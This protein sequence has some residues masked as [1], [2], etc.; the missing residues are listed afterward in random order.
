MP[1]CQNRDPDS[2]DESDEYSQECG[3]SNS[4]EDEWVYI[5]LLNNFKKEKGISAGMNAYL[6]EIL[7]LNTGQILIYLSTLSK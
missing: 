2:V 3:F 6:S 5:S 7:L 1:L 4:Y